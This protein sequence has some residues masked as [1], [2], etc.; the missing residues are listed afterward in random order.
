MIKKLEGLKA[1]VWSAL[2]VS[3]AFILVNSTKD[4]WI[5][6]E[7]LIAQ[8]LVVLFTMVILFSLQFG[9][10][11]I[12]LLSILW[13]AYYAITEFG[14]LDSMPFSGNKQWMF[15]AGT[16]CLTILAFIQDRGMLSLH[17]IVRVV[18]FAAVIALA[19]LWLYLWQE[20][21]TLI[22][23][24]DKWQLGLSFFQ[25]DC[26]VY[27]AGLVLLAKSIKQPNL[28]VSALLTTL[29]IWTLMFN[30]QLA[31]TN[32]VILTLLLCHY[33]LI[34]VIDSYY[35]AFRDELTGLPSRRAL[36]QFILSLGRKYTV[37]MLD[38]DHFK[39]FNDNYG[40]D[41]GDQVLKLVA[42]KLSKVKSGGRVFRYGGEEF[43]I[44]FPRKEIK[45]TLA[46]LEKL[47]NDVANYD[48]VIRHPLR[49]TKKARSKSNANNDLKTVNVTI[50]IGVASRAPKALFE[51][52]LKSADEALYRAKKAG[53][54]NVCQ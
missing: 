49:K 10:S 36:M 27:F 38:V 3:I 43:T 6:F 1:T 15:I 33:L 24:Y 50:S 16:F 4:Y 2:L 14:V 40:H 30:Q 48:I 37:A 53:R 25:I 45:E 18:L 41:I 47:R 21:Y 7:P 12:T 11:R 26:V 8:I 44:V 34:V 39:K 32:S 9:R 23:G 22:K 19:Q 52:T 29:V 5:S 35:L 20:G 46:E 31:L 51:Q 28:F 42:A 17:G 13:L 54:N